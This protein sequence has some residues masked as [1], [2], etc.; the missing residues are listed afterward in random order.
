MSVELGDEQLAARTARTER[1][2]RGALAAVLGL[3]ALVTLLVP[4]T[5]AFTTG[6]GA[7]RAAALIGLAALMIAAAGTVRRRWGIGFGSALQGAFILTGILLPAMFVVGAIF[8]AIWGR[9]LWLRHEL[10]GR[11]GGWRVLL[12]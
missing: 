9:L 8:A 7:A 1:M 2:T 5:I 11:P 12:G 4:R 3:E 10:A 6:L